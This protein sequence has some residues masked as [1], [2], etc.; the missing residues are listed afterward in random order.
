MATTINIRS[1]RSITP[2]E[3][4]EYINENIDLRDE[5]AVLNSAEQFSALNNNKAFALDILHAELKRAPNSNETSF[6]SLHSCIVAR[7][8]PTRPEQSYMLRLNI[9]PCVPQSALTVALAQSVHQL[10]GYDIPHDHNFSFMTAG[11]W[12][13]GYE[14]AVFEY[15]CAES[16]PYPNDALAL[17]F[18][19]RT[20]L[21]EG[22]IM[23][24]RTSRD[25]HIQFAP[26]EPSMSLNL[27][28]NLPE[29][30]HVEQYVVDLDSQRIAEYIPFSIITKRTRIIECVAQLGDENSVELLFDILQKHPA[31]RLR[32]AAL[33]ALVKVK[34]QEVDRIASVAGVDPDPW[35]RTTWSSL[36]IK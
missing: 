15:E 27:L 1:Q 25:V 34:P 30:Q 8:K 17:R 11:Y 29:N 35:I 4:I 3:Y 18:L 33:K 7:G 10:Y 28:I 12:G 9:W 22:K 26:S 20:F 23:Y 13:P 24:F 5:A 19:E 2:Q 36:E 31:R 32:H 21:S 16:Q 6:Y 14:T